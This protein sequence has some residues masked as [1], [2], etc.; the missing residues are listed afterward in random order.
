MK[1]KKDIRTDRYQQLL[2]SFDGKANS[3]GGQEAIDQTADVR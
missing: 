3:V 1:C 2:L